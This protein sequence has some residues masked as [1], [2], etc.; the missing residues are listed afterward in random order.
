[1]FS[2]YFIFDIIF[3]IKL[4]NRIKTSKNVFEKLYVFDGKWKEEKKSIMHVVLNRASLFE[5]RCF[6]IVRDI[7]NFKKIISE[8]NVEAKKRL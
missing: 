3:L 2:F 6:A 5:C 8:K 4:A 7:V 1:M